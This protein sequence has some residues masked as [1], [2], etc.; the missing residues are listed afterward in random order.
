[1][2]DPILSMSASTWKRD[3]HNLFDYESAEISKQDMLV[4]SS[5]YLLRIDNAVTIVQD[6]ST[7][8]EI[9][10]AQKL[11]RVTK[12]SQGFF[13]SSC[14]DL[15]GEPLWLVIRELEGNAQGFQ[16]MS[17]SVLKLGRV[18]LVMRELENEHEVLST[19][20]SSDEEED[21]EKICRICFTGSYPDDP[22]VSPCI[23]SGTARYIHFN[24]LKHW[25]DMKRNVAQNETSVAYFWESFLCEICKHALPLSMKV[26]GKRY[27]LFRLDKHSQT[28]LVLE[29][30]RKDSQTRGVH[31][32]SMKPNSRVCLGRGHESDVRVSDISVSRLHAQLNYDGA[33]FYLKDNSS[34]FGSLLQ[35]TGPLHIGI[36]QK[37]VLQ[38]GRTVI[39]FEATNVPTLAS[40]SKY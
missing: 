29:V 3:S 10:Q 35:V 15:G 37:A 13:I 38:M 4:S 23:C 24:C 7:I 21:D 30:V 19:E 22:L 33:Q 31:L 2:E 18:K 16:L 36:S 1:M 26:R 39:S 25:I 9:A 32:I 17:G 11:A 14:E 40:C 34:K 28:T 6:L 8:D 20:N 5:C 12:T 27:D